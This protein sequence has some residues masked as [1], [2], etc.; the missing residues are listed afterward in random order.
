[1]AQ[2]RLGTAVPTQ[3]SR[4]RSTVVPVFTSTARAVT[5][6]PLIL[7]G[8]RSSRQSAKTGVAVADVQLSTSQYDVSAERLIAVNALRRATIER[9]NQLLIRHAADVRRGL[10]NEM[11][12][13]PMD[14]LCKLGVRLNDVFDCFKV[15]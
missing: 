7:V 6:R 14:R 2:L 15:Q 10:I 11:P 1:M 4:Y 8:S 3:R 5:A 9:N 13:P 12:D